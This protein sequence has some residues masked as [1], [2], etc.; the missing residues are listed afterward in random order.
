LREDKEKE[1]V[2]TGALEIHFINMVKFRRQK[3]KDIKNNLLERWVSFLDET[4]AQ[5]VIE[6]IV[7]MDSEIQKTA[8]K[9]GFLLQDKD[10]LDFYYMRAMAKSDIT[11][12]L[13]TALEQGEQ[14]GIQIGKVDIARK[15]L[16]AGLN[17]EMIETITGLDKDTI[18]RLKG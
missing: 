9:L 1:Y 6:E 3:E 2:L 18:N 12:G 10:A 13:N 11:T 17:V 16:Y 8:D 4:T 7:Q 5:D 14:R 15:A